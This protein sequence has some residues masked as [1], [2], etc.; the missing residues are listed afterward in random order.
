MQVSMPLISES[1][2]RISGPAQSGLPFG[3]DL[4]TS[5]VFFEV[6]N[7]VSDAIAPHRRRRRRHR[8]IADDAFE[9]N[10]VLE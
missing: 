9:A 5:P 6:E 8:R 7:L 3:A 10:L 4:L 1:R 2:N